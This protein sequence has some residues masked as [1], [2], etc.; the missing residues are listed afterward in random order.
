METRII[1]EGGHK[2]RATK[3]VCMLC[4]K[5]FW[6]RPRG[7][8][9]CSIECA[10]L[11]KRNRI[12]LNCDWCEKEFVR[13]PSKVKASKSGLQF[14]SRKCKD[15]AQ[16]IGGKSEIQPLHYGNGKRAYR[17]I[18]FALYNHEC[19][20][21]EYN[22]F[23]VLEVH[24]VDFEHENNSPDN[25]IILCPTCHATKHWKKRMGM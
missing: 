3:H 19:A 1:I 15:T 23:P 6:A 10:R 11:S 17:K 4:E 5:E 22:K 9:Y 21:C 18:A 2:R 8:K 20:E 13:T 14:C 7:R 24:H 16:C 25:L 12:Q